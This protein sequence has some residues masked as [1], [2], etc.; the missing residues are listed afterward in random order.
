MESWW[1]TYKVFPGTD[2]SVT[3]EQ[4]KEEI[5]R[6]LQAIEV[7]DYEEINVGFV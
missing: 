5:E 2:N 4:L 1:Q 3:E 6:A 7:G